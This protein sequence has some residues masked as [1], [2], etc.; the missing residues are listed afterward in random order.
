[1]YNWTFWEI[2]SSL[3]RLWNDNL[4]SLLHPDVKD[5]LHSKI[6]SSYVYIS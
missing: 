3:L 2:D 4:T 6:Y 5:A 1:M